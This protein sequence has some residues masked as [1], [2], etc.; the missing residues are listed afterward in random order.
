MIAE[1]RSSKAMLETILGSI[2]AAWGVLMAISP[3]L[4]IRKMLHH[5]SSREVSIAYFWVIEVG[6]ALWVVY[7][8]TIKNWFLVIPNA[9]AFTVCGTTIAIALRFR[10]ESGGG[11]FDAAA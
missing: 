3:A 2:A 6:F 4:Q 7:G 9:V 11:A 10:R 5:R 1:A 8:V